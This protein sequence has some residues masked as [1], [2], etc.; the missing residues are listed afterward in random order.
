MRRGLVLA[1]AALVALCAVALAQSQSLTVAPQLTCDACAGRTGTVK[2]GLS[3]TLTYSSFPD[4]RISR[5]LSYYEGV[6]FGTWF[7][8]KNGGLTVQNQPLD[9]QLYTMDNTADNSRAA[10][11][12]RYA[13]HSTS[14]HARCASFSL[15]R[16]CRCRRGGV[17][18]SSRA[19]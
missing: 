11:Q 4:S 19:F 1:V 15:C 5:Y 10:S 3:A 2:L 6:R 7:L 8:N 16:R 9:V 18:I 17:V 12:V 14:A 13:Y